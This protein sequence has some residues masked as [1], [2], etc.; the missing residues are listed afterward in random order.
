MSKFIL[1]LIFFF[2]FL[3][4]LAKVKREQEEEHIEIVFINKILI[5]QEK[6]WIKWLDYYN[7][8]SS[9][10]S[11]VID[12]QNQSLQEFLTLQVISADWGFKLIG[13]RIFIGLT[14]FWFIDTFFNV[15]HYFWIVWHPDNFYHTSSLYW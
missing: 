7:F 6:N 2:F 5:F 14:W 15:G 10:N 11:L 3:L 9:K 1:Y 13:I 12:F 8:W 4:I